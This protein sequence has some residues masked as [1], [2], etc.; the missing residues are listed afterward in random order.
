[1]HFI[2]FWFRSDYGYVAGDPKLG[3]AEEKTSA[4]KILGSAKKFL[5]QK[6]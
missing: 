6:S 4:K 2:D 1:L 3:S 5:T